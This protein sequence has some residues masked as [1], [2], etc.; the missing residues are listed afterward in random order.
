[1]R[2]KTFQTALLPEFLNYYLNSETGQ[3]AI[4]AF[5][6]PGVSQS[7]VSAGS[8]KKLHVPVPP[9]GDQTRIVRELGKIAAMKRVVKRHIEYEQAVLGTLANNLLG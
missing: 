7:N 6:T 1:V 3:R 4:R 2:I 8:L 5:A 9:L